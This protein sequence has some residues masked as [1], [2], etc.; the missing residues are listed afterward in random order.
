MSAPIPRRPR[1]ARSLGRDQMRIRR[2]EVTAVASIPTAATATIQS[3]AAA[4]AAATYDVDFT[5]PTASLGD[6]IG[7]TV[8]T[9]TDNGNPVSGFFLP[10]GW[11]Y[12]ANASFLVKT[13]AAPAA[14][15]FLKWYLEAIPSG[16]EGVHGSYR[17]DPL[18]D[19]S[20]LLTP[21]QNIG[22]SV[23][24]TGSDG[25]LGGEHGA[26]VVLGRIES[27]AGTLFTVTSFVLEV[28]GIKVGPFP[29]FSGTGVF[30]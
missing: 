28:W 23:G 13:A 29:G 7:V 16:T 19:T 22:T 26:Q 14:G 8:K 9:G 4:A 2:L 5:D 12:V 30:V 27:S 17:F 3:A 21:F 20:G 1:L 6:D 10:P 25:S 24:A 18:Y 11:V 15:E